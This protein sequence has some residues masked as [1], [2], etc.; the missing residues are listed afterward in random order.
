MRIDFN[1]GFVF[2]ANAELKI[3]AYY[4]TICSGEKCCPWKS[5][6][7]PIGWI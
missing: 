5:D 4:K 6:G 3:A 2:Q 1:I 7:P